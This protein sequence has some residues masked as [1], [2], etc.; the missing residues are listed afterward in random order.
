MKED[1]LSD[2]ESGE[3]KHLEQVLVL[4]LGKGPDF[5]PR[6]ELIEKSEYEVAMVNSLKE[7][8]KNEPFSTSIYT[9]MTNRSAGWID[10]PVIERRGRSGQRACARAPVKI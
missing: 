1:L 8:M 9:E 5:K 3:D 6:M 10:R 4:V 2:T 7:L